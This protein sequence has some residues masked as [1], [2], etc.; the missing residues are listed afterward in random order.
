MLLLYNLEFSLFRIHYNILP[1]IRT[2]EN[3][4]MVVHKSYMYSPIFS[5]AA[6]FYPFH[7]VHPLADPI[8]V[9]GAWNVSSL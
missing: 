7:F 4:Q 5:E 1:H 8:S 6:P 9:M 2:K 3:H